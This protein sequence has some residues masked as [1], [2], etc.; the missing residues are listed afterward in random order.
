MVGS[1]N[2]DVS[3]I[4]PNWNGRFLLEK[5]LYKVIHALNDELNYKTEIIIVD[6]ASQDDSVNF[7][8]NKFKNEIRLITHSENKGFGKSCNDGVKASKG[9]IIIL[10][11]SDVIPYM[12]F[13]SPLMIHFKDKNVFAVSCNDG[14]HHAVGYY[15]RGFI[16]HK[17]ASEISSKICNSFWVSGGS[18]AFDKNKWQKL[19]GFS[20]VFKPF[21]WEDTDL[22]YRALKRG[23]KIY[24]EPNSKVNHKHETTIA[25]HFTRK[26]IDQVSLNNQIL[27]FY[28]NISDKNLLLKNFFWAI[29]Y[30][31][32]SNKFRKAYFNLFI[33]LPSII[34]FRKNEKRILSDKDILNL[35]K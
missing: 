1:K 27:F 9:K 26:Y 15:N 2:I 6:D 4:I 23:W 12:G 14:G 16:Y 28:R 22:C 34:K 5:N 19:N 33:Q 10:L 30:C 32:R 35:A 7:L 29:I 13:L 18:A 11:N 17:P 21:Y 8:N 20:H 24:W 25:S 31:I 3:V